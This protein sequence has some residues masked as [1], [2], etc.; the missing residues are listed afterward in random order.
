M[1]LLKALVA[2]KL[3]AVAAR[4]AIAL[5]DA[6]MTN[7]NCAKGARELNPFV[8]P[9]VRSPG[10]YAVTQLDVIA[11]GVLI[12][13]RPQ[14]RITKAFFAEAAVSHTWGVVTNLRY[15]PLNPASLTFVCAHF[16]PHGADET[17]E[18]LMRARR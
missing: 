7:S 16:G 6:V 17:C 12:F 1:I 4:S 18:Y 14:S 5:T 9:F 10:I 8:R 15:K 13:A 2:K 3:A 11:T